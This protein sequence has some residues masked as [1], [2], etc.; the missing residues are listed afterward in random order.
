M[1]TV[2][3]PSTCHYVGDYAFN[4]CNNIT[5]TTIA[6][7]VLYV[8]DYAF[9]NCSRL[10][11]IVIPDTCEYLGKG[12]FYNCVGMTSASIGITVPEI[13]DYTFTNCSSMET[14]VIGLKVTSIG[15]YAFK[16]C[17]SIK[18]IALRSGII[19]V[20]DGAFMNCSSITRATL[21]ATI[22]EIGPYAFYGCSSLTSI[23]VPKLVT[24]I[25]ESTFEG[26]TSLTSASYNGTV[27]KIGNRSFY[28]TCITTF[29][30]KSGLEHLG[31]ESFS[32][33]KLTSVVLPD[34]LQI[35]GEH[36]FDG[37]ELQSVSMPSCVKLDNNCKRIF[38]NNGNDMIVTIRFVNDGKLDDYLLYRSNANQVL[39]DEGITD[40]GDY[41]FARN[42]FTAITLP[43]TLTH[44]GDYAFYLCENLEEVTLPKNTKTVGTYTFAKNFNLKNIYIP[45]SMESVGSHAFYKVENE[46]VHELLTVHIYFN[47]GK[48]CNSLLSSQHM[49]YVIIL[50]DVFQVGDY[51][52]ANCPNLREVSV[53]DCI[54]SFG[55]NNFLNDN[56]VTLEIRKVDG[57]ID[58]YV[59]Y[60]NLLYVTTVIIKEDISA[61]GKYAFYNDTSLKIISVPNTVNYIGEYAFYNCNSIKEINI[62]NGVAA[63]YSHTFFGCSSLESITTPNTVKLIGDYAFYGCVEAKTLTISNSCESIGS[64]AFY[65]CKS[66]KELIIP[67]SVKTIG[68]YAFR[69]CVEIT[70]LVFSNNVEEIGACAFYDCNGLRTVKLGKK[71]IAL[72]D[73]MFYGCVNLESLYV[74]A[75]LSYIDELAFYGADFVTVYCGRDDYMIN[76]FDENGIFYEILDDLVYEYKI[77]FVNNDGEIISS[78]T[79]TSGS[80][81]TLPAN[82]T[83]PSDN[84]YNYVFAGWDQ[85]VTIVGGNKTYTAVFTPVYID[86]TVV[87]KDYNGNILSS[88]TYHYGD[89]I[90]I[91]SDPTRAADNTYTYAFAGWDNAVV[92]CTANAVYTAT[93]TPTYI[94]YT[95]V[96]EDW[97]GTIIS[98]K[99]YHYGDE[100]TAP[101]NPTK[102]ADNTYTYAFAGWDKEVDDCTGNVTYT[103]TYNTTYIDYTVEFMDADGT[104]IS[105]QT[106]HYG[107]KVIAPTEPQKAADNTYTYAFAG[108]DKAV[109]GCVGNA[110]YTATY[111]PTYIDY[112]VV[113]K[114]WNGAVI[115]VKTY[116]WGDEVTVPADPARAA[117]NTYTYAFSGWD[118]KVVNCAGNVTYTAT[119]TPAYIDY[120]VIFENADGGVISKKIYHW[121]EEITIPT[122]P[123]KDMDHIGSYSFAGWDKNIVACNGNATYTATYAIDYTDY[124]VVFQ[125][126]DGD[127]IS[128]GTYHW[129]DSIV[130]PANPTKA[131]DNTYTYLF[132]GWDNEVVNCAGTA[133][134][135]ATYTPVYINYTIVFKNWDDSVLS[136][137]TYHWGDVVTTPTNPT[138]VADNTYTYAFTG[139][140]RN[141]VDCAGNATYIAQYD[142]I[143]RD[144]TVVFKDWNGTVL[145]SKTY[146]WG[147]QVA[148]PQ[149]PTRAADNT[150]TYTFAGWD[151]DVVN[152]AGNATYTATYNATYID[153]TVVF[154]DWNGEVLSTMKYHYGDK[155]TAPTAPAKAADNTYTY[156]F[157]GWDKTVVNCAGNATYTATYNSNY[158]NYTVVFKNWNGTV[159]S[160]KTYHYGDKVTVPTTPTKAANN[161]YTYT[162]AGWDKTI[163]N[164]AGKATYTATYTQTYID[165]T[166]TFKNWDGSVI[167]TDTYHYGDVVQEPNIPTKDSDLYGTYVFSGWDK[168]VTNCAGNATYTATYKVEY[169]DYLVSFQNWDGTLVS[170]K[171]YHYGDT[172]VVPNDPVRTSDNTY[173]YTFIG[174][175]KDVVNC[176]GN[177]TYIAQYDATLRDYTITFRDWN[178]NLIS[179]N[180]YHWGDQVIAPADP[181]RESDNTYT[182]SFS[183][184]DRAVANCAGNATYTATFKAA[185]IDYTVV[186]KNW[187]DT[188]IS[189]KTY[190]WGDVVEQPQTPVREQDRYYTYSFYGWDTEVVSCAGNAAYKATYA[191]KLIPAKI[192]SQPKT[193]KIKSGATAKFIVE[194]DG[195]GLTYQ[196]Q[197]SSDGKTWKNC[198]S[199]S[200]TKATFSFTSKTSHNGNYYRCKVTDGEGNVVYTSAVRLYVLG[201]TTQPKTQT[202]KSGATVKFTV[203]ATGT[204]LK[205]QWQSSTNGK[206][207]K[208]CSSSSATKA[209]FSFTSKTSHNGNYYRCKVT[210]SAGNVVYTSSVRA[211]VLG[212]T[213]QP[214]TQKVE[215]GETVKFTVKA[216]GTGLKY[217]WQVSTDG[218]TWKNCTSSSAKK[219]TFTFTSKNSH[220]S[221]Y[222]RCRIK[223]NAGNTVYTDAVRLY[224]LGI[225]TQPT[226]KTVK[227]GATAKFT[228]KAT[229]AGKTYQWQVSTDGGKTW[230]NCSSSSATKATFSFTSKTSHNG[231]YYRC[232]VTD[233]AGNVV[234]TSSVRAYVLGVT[235]QPKTQKV[236]S[237]E[238]V[239]FTVKATGTGLKYQ[240]QVSTDGKTWKN[241]T[242]SSAKKA[243][244]TFTSKNSHSSNYYRC[245]IK[246]NAGNTV[247]TDAVRLY[248]LGITTQPTAKTVKAGATAKFTVK[249]TGA[250]KTYQWQVSTDGG[251]TWTNCSSS[252]AKKATFTFTSKTSHNG[253][254]Y[255]CRVKDNGGNTIYTVKVKLTVKK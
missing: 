72:G 120:I 187:D 233:S 123:M 13:N 121:G 111:T 2:T 225:T 154:K 93:Y 41:A 166:V 236:E 176:A 235:T 200:A 240:W 8:G 148:I 3:I 195:I 18:A 23:T 158:I 97:D 32:H 11:S 157:A 186:F 160:S 104:V 17:S 150:Y 56:N 142:A 126:W 108:W 208:N 132:A 224:V 254:Y 16:N 30:F 213:T 189:S 63:I 219:A 119:Y 198:S 243:T 114:N 128:T 102:E 73:R 125:N 112:T 201:V 37:C 167:A 5:T 214:K 242:S 91:P 172:V 50:D 95:I 48:I 137:K 42:T 156:S 24:V 21:A 185:Y 64:N 70:E 33:T 81:V 253:N 20:G 227:A 212:V 149:N 46:E 192:T 110:T 197:S 183:G 199:S 106:Y 49:Q 28:G 40:I 159:L 31:S 217:Q 182:Y 252:S 205:Y 232:K 62:P 207:W 36:V 94:D 228:V 153:Y 234:Y 133:T 116:H 204:G 124:T 196:W 19:S 45:D 247:Y 193:Q 203:K 90:T 178:G 127:V 58:D 52:F 151:S 184:W 84:T 53:G 66:I 170:S 206:T 143:L 103:A 202:V 230:T 231:N 246:D 71:I 83:K 101:S 180:A 78:A 173:T 99:T 175:D 223:D 139:W 9:F 164:C 57:Y 88:Q 177:T 191:A 211:Y 171:T 34:S 229:G 168:A 113:F 38:A 117:D 115:T 129:G 163:V 109:V 146:H 145:S 89:A 250:G 190:H 179:S 118:S 136:T 218:K 51:V 61:I 27:T 25:P 238:T 155:I 134:Y 82:P 215:S 77:T 60:D 98:T 239:K 221:N 138:K 55:N 144:Y 1:T 141:I 194:A 105:T 244:F 12:A 255:R 147:D 245:R 220:S 75:P 22:T 181:I 131:A 96:F 39:I 15:D 86:Y 100:V 54:S 80:I 68:T 135:T 4:G 248:V 241:C 188:V 165:Y 59:Y 29:N 10:E 237:G 85:D 44:I 140:D 152:C 222:Y 47:E 210:D 6:E 65:N 87:F 92:D 169:T 67:D 69:S 216:T 76:F 79:Y 43:N 161:T 209:T 35:I 174:W 162:F 74:Y 14:I 122:D 26:C 130:I 249:A 7:G 107:D 226:A 251:K